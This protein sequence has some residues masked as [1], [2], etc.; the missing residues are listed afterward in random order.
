MKAKATLKDALNLV[1]KA[2]LTC[3]VLRLMSNKGHCEESNDELTKKL[4]NPVAS[5]ISIPFQNN[6]KVGIGANNGYCNTLNI[7]AIIPFS[8]T[9][10]YNI[11]SRVVAPIIFQNCVMT[12]E[13]V[14]K[15]Y[16][17]WWP[18]PSCRL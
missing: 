6:T 5:L 14:S 1:V 9:L 13:A 2:S 11:V 3:F 8:F 18:V 7:Q 15:A 10:Q 16:R 17:T 12:V 4:N